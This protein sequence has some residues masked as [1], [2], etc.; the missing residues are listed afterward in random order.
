[1]V[2]PPEPTHKFLM[3]ATYS[4]EGISGID[5]VNF[6]VVSS[7]KTYLPGTDKYLCKESAKLSD[8]ILG[9]T[10]NVCGTGFWFTE[11]A[12]LGYCQVTRLESIA[13]CVLIVIV[14]NNWTFVALSA[15]EDIQ[16]GGD[17]A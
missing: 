17:C 12:K 7:T 6:N 9:I 11:L 14:G 15:G 1:M 3:T 8:K 10:C 4:I 13:V 2:I 16:A 5:G